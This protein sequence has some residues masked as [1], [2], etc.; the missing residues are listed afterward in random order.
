MASNADNVMTETFRHN[1]HIVKIQFSR[2]IG[3][4]RYR[5]CPNCCL[6]KPLDS[7]FGYRN[8]G[9]GTIQNQ[10]WCTDYR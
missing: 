4:I 3:G 2:Y 5:V 6:E 10:S 8:M 9:N 1:G 7:D